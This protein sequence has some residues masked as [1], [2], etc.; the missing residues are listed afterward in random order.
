M[1]S[2]IGSSY[3]FKSENTRQ[4]NGCILKNIFHIYLDDTDV[5]GLAQPISPKSSQNLIPSNT[6][7]GKL[8]LQQSLVIAEIV[9]IDLVE[10]AIDLKIVI[11][12]KKNNKQCFIANP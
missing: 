4:F 5:S 8:F 2:Q 11:S 6:K 12:G 9:N 10:V 7:T 3:N 1:D